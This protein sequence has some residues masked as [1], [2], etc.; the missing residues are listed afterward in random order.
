MVP[1]MEPQGT[2][3][4]KKS[5]KASTQ[6][7]SKTQH[8]QKW[9][10]GSILDPKRGGPFRGRSAPKI[11]QIPKIINMSPR[12]SKMSPRASK[13]SPLFSKLTKTRDSDLLKSTFL[14]SYTVISSKTFL[15]SW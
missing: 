2:I 6:K 3:N 4:H 12:A 8:C 9:L 15:V 7:T 14:I 11:T 10:S 13:M 1:E 5:T